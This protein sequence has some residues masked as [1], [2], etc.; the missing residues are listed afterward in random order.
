MDSIE[1]VA[2]QGEVAARKTPDSWLVF[3]QALKEL[4]R[5]A[6]SSS[7]EFRR[8]QRVSMVLGRLEGRRIP[9]FTFT[10]LPPAQ[11]G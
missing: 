9:M 5:Q 1:W 11:V 10:S 2:M 7:M 6:G 4:R 3:I 8:V